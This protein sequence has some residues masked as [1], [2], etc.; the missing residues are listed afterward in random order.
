MNAHTI[1]EL[2]KALGQQAKAAS[3]FMAKASALHKST[4][5][6]EDRKSV[7]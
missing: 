4:A 7:V 2:M 3:A 6:R 1:P 5:L